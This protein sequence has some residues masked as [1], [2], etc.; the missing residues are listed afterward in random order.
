MYFFEDTTTIQKNIKKLIED[1]SLI[2]LNDKIIL[3]CDDCK[4]ILQKYW[5]ITYHVNYWY[6]D[7]CYQSNEIHDIKCCSDCVYGI[8]LIHNP[9]FKCYRE[10]KN[11]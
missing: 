7:K 2:E 10:I 5:I 4:K 1:Y 6:H 11:E 3:K 9:I 8:V